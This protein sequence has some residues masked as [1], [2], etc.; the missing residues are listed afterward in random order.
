M[1]QIQA[2]QKQS[3]ARKD[4]RLKEMSN[5]TDPNLIKDF[6]TYRK[7]TLEDLE[8]IDDVEGRKKKAGEID[9]EMM[10]FL[11]SRGYDVNTLDRNSEIA[12]RMVA[13][14]SELKQDSQRRKRETNLENRQNVLDAQV[15]RDDARYA[16]RDARNRMEGV[17]HANMQQLYDMANDPNLDDESRTFASMMIEID[18]K[19]KRDPDAPLN[20][21]AIRN[22]Q[23]IATREYT[24][25]TDPAK[26]QTYENILF[27]LEEREA[28]L[29]GS[30]QE[31]D[32]RR[33][34]RYVYDHPEMS[35]LEVLDR[36][37]G[38]DRSAT[39]MLGGTVP[40]DSRSRNRLNSIVHERRRVYEERLGELQRQRENTDDLTRIQSIDKEI[41]DLVRS[42]GVGLDAF[43][44]E[45]YLNDIIREVARNTDSAGLYATSANE[46]GEIP[47]FDRLFTEYI[48]RNDNREPVSEE[49]EMTIRNRERDPQFWRLFTHRMKGTM[50]QM[51]AHNAKLGMD[52]LKQAQP[53]VDKNGKIVR[54][55]TSLT[56]KD[57]MDQGLLGDDSPLRKELVDLKEYEDKTLM[58]VINNKTRKDEIRFT[59]DV[60]QYLR[61]ANSPVGYTQGDVSRAILS[62]LTNIREELQN[63]P[64]DHN[65]D[66]VSSDTNSGS[67]DNNA[68]SDEPESRRGN[69]PRAAQTGD[70]STPLYE[71]DY[72]GSEDNGIYFLDK[73]GNRT[74]P[75][76]MNIMDYGR[77]VGRISDYINNGYSSQNG[78]KATFNKETGEWEGDPDA[79]REI[80]AIHNT[81]NRIEPL[82]FLK[83]IIDHREEFGDEAADLADMAYEA[84][85]LTDPERVIGTK[86]IKKFEAVLDE[87]ERLVES[88]T[89][90]SDED[91]LYGSKFDRIFGEGIG[92]NVYNKP[93]SQHKMFKTYFTPTTIKDSTDENGNVNTRGLFVRNMRRRLDQRH[94]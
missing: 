45:L 86:A 78:D 63:R 26:K 13:F 31:L 34:N 72:V 40:I 82:N 20:I 22:L 2:M 60:A 48:R 88:D 16:T 37:Y 81:H 57:L 83:T 33:F 41:N 4:A 84:I 5:P 29:T 61:E 39:N 64:I 55:G 85:I 59:E 92:L 38:Y 12:K 50:M 8:G 49:M 73:D 76:R 7:K 27:E 43:E 28:D 44:G 25:E 23:N 14:T 15:A 35:P 56:I 79:V 74:T 17:F 47:A 51:A 24:N 93:L 53:V 32:A 21:S 46:R 36:V 67:E 58:E 18:P 71:M 19:G 65:A 90:S 68:T 9:K 89:S 91:A 11:T 80:E 77:S 66:N 62:Q 70:S 10:D 94:F 30:R 52:L 6:E 3:K 1:N 87:V 75:G 69:T 54:H 42:E